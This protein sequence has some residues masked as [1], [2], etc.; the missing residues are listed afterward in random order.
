MRILEENSNRI[1]KAIEKFIPRSLTEDSMV[2]R[3]YRPRYAYNVEALNVAIFHPIWDLLNRGGKRWRPA[4][5]LMIVEA[6]GNNSEQYVDF[7]MIPEVVHNGTLMVDDIEDASEMRRGKPCSY[8]LFGVDV[9]VNAGNLMYFLPLIALA[10]EKSKISPDRLIRIYEVFVE[11]MVNL[12]FGQAMD[13]AW[14][15]GIASAD[16]INEKQYLQM[17]AYKTGTLARMAARM[18]AIIGQAN[19]DFTTKIGHFAE[20][21]GI[22]FQ[23]QDDVLDLI[24]QEFAEKKGGNGQD[25]TEGKRTL[26]VIRT[27]EAA[28]L[29]DR[30]RLLE[31]L[32]LHTRDQKLRNEAILIM[33]KY[34]S[35]DYAKKVAKELVRESWNEINPYLKD[36]EAKDKL[37]LFADFL[38]ERKI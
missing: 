31:I 6:L 22:A 7:A 1:D 2:F 32:N 33:R 13:I 3:L 4:L 18:A 10:K 35:I 21:I 36:T 23:I 25:I 28:S 30:S 14:H 38:I 12:S 17:C 34:D 5:F 20:S 8:R 37:K 15:K 24:S 19:E 9:A 27:L 11:E 26:M 29:S 16:Q